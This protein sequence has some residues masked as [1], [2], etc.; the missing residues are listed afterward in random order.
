MN[1]KNYLFMAFSKANNSVEAGESSVKR[2]WGV[3]PVKIVAVNPTKKELEE[4]YGTTL[5]KDPEYCSI[6]DVNGSQIHAARIDF[7]VKTDV[8]KTGVDMTSKV[9]FFVQKTLQ[10]N[11]DQTK[12]Q[13]MDK[14]GETAWATLEE[15]KEHQ[16]PQYAN[17]PATIDKDYHAVC[18]G[19]VELTNFIRTYLCLEG[20]RVWDSKTST[21]IDNPK[22]EEG[23][24]DHIKEY[25]DGNFTE[26]KDII[27]LMPD[28][29][30]KVLFGVRT[31]EDNKQY[32]TAYTRMFLRN[33]QNKLDRIKDDVAKSKAAGAYGNIE[34]GPNG[35]IDVISEYTVTPTDFEEKKDEE[36]LVGMPW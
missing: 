14:Y 35:V 22:K 18:K 20:A 36:P 8:D 15:V 3:A 16:I 9:T 7:I 19:E 33:S 10:T 32:Q 29:K 21:M 24:L 6:Q 34:F 31:T 25:F 1:N 4:I 13:I 2:Y 23:C 11:R 17:G 12:C 28:N 27:K 30:V 5:D 26:L